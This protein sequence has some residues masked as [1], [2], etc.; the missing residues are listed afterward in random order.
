MKPVILDVDTGIDDTLAIAY[1]AHSPELELIGLTTCFGNISLEDA[2]RNSLLV[3][4]SL[5]IDVP[6][7]PGASKPLFR[8]FLKKFATEVHGDDGLGNTVQRAPAGKAQST[9]A[10]RFLVDAVRSRPKQVTIIAVGPLTNLALALMSDPEFADSVGQV[11][12][13]GGAVTVPGNVTPHAEANIYADPE[14]AEYVFRSGLPIVLVGLDV[15]MQTLLSRDCVNEWK[16][17]ETPLSGFL[18]DATSFYIDAYERFRPGI[19]GCALHDPL[20][21][22]VAIDPTF[23]RAVPMHVQVD[24]E[25]MYSL[26]RTIGDRRASPRLEPNMQVCLEVDAERFL[27]HFL[28]RI[29]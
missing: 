19:G 29:L 8:D 10:A 3:L 16:R 20:A 22:G 1:A 6:V 18:A 7:Y 13:M 11:V 12:I 23:V 25:G 17:A 26:G 15:T 24:L 27:K 9:P 4:E 14:A 28:E 2:T 21:V 5:G